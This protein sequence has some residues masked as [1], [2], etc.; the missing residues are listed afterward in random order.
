MIETEGL[1]ISKQKKYIRE[2]NLNAA[3]LGLLATGGKMDVILYDIRE[4]YPCNI[5]PGEQPDLMEFFY[6]LEGIAV[7]KLSD[8]EVE[9]GKGDFFYVYNLKTIINF[10]THQG[11]KLLCISSQPSFKYLLEYHEGLSNLLDNVESKDLYT[12]NHGNRVQMYS[13]KIG[14]KL[15]LSEDKIYVLQIASLFH[16]IGKYFV[17]DDILKKPD[18][19]TQEE[20][21]RIKRHSSD[22]SKLLK[23]QF[24]QE[25]LVAVEQHHERLDGTGYPKG[26]RGE[27]IT[28]EARII[29]V[30]D[31]Y[32]AITSDRAYRG[33]KSP[34][35]AITELTNFSQHYDP[36][37]V[38]ALREILVEEGE[39]KAEEI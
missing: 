2:I 9:L 13:L 31:T 19:L 39:I 38:R 17:P 33:A 23:E 24:E 35:A 20:Y 29:A 18:K 22:S 11:A 26:L 7:I 3:T 34:L 5:C 32:D 15:N 25:I 37:V 10:T 6:V 12:Y 21:E 36:I 14:E 8:N 30:A 27:Q 4:D 16:D 1:F 28:L